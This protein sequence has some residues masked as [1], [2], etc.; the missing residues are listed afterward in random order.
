MLDFFSTFVPTSNQVF[1]E[2][3]T[4]IKY[5]IGYFTNGHGHEHEAREHINER[6]LIDHVQDMMKR[7]NI[8][9]GDIEKLAS[10]IEEVVDDEV[11]E[12]DFNANYD[13]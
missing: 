2:Y 12:A 9:K 10:L 6:A 3:G 5:R 13:G 1:E 4:G 8:E 11:S 7:Y